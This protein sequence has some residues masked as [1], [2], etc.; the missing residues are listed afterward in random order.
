MTLRAFMAMKGLTVEEMG[1]MLGVS[2]VSVS[3]YRNGLRRPEWDILARIIKVTQGAVTPN[4]FL[5]KTR[6]RKTAL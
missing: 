4:D 6:R 2:H 5:P 3:R 1:R